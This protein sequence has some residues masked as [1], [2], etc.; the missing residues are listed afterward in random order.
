[1]KESGH[2][3]RGGGIIREMKMKCENLIL[4][5]GKE[6]QRGTRQGSLTSKVQRFHSVKDKNVSQS[7]TPCKFLV[8]ENTTINNIGCLYFQT[9]IYV[10]ILRIITAL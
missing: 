1:M 10:I 6:D 4:G 8:N 2:E 5:I 7:C 9:E 3:L